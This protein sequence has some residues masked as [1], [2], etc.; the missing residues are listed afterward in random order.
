MRA[1]NALHPHF[2][3]CQVLSE[4]MV[5]LISVYANDISST[6]AVSREK[7]LHDQPISANR[8]IRK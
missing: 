3:I 2:Y 1:G 7:L 6:Y 8:V 5:D 4:F